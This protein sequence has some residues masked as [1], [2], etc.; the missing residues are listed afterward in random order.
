[1]KFA[2]RLQL[3]WVEVNGRPMIEPDLLKWAAWFEQSSKD[4]ARFVAKTQVGEYQVSTVFLGLDH[5][6]G[7]DDDE[8]PILYETMVFKNGS[9]SDEDCER[10]ATRD[11]A[12]RGHDEMV[13]KYMALV[14][15]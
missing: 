2:D 4:G 15:S 14:A 13:A 12:Q 10:Y 3:H 5:G 9:N 1:M 11:E 7:L 6:F 8:P